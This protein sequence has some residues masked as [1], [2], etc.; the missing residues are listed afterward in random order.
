MRAAS[1]MNPVV[2]G[3]VPLL[4]EKGAAQTWYE[5]DAAWYA[6]RYG[7][8][9]MRK[10]G[11]APL[12]QHYLQ[13][14]RQKG[15]SP[16]SYFDEAWYLRRYAEVEAQVRRGDIASGFAHYCANSTGTYA[17]HWLFDP[18]Y[19]RSHDVELSARSKEGTIFRDDYDH[20]LQVGARMGLAPSVFFDEA[21]YASSLSSEQSTGLRKE[22]GYRHYLRRFPQTLPELRLSSYFEPFAYLRKYPAVAVEIL[23]GR[24]SSALE[25]FLTAPDHEQFRPSALFSERRY[26]ELN[27]DLASYVERDGSNRAA[28]KHFIRF[29][30]A[31]NRKFHDAIDL[32]DYVN[33]NPAVRED[34]ERG[35]APNAYVHFVEIGTRY[36]LVAGNQSQNLEG[37]E[38]ATKRAFRNQAVLNMLALG[39]SAID[40]SYIGEPDVSVIVVLH[41][42]FPLTVSALASLR[43][44]YCGNI[45][46]I[47]VDSGST[48]RTLKI[49]NHV[50]GA[51][52]IRLPGNPG[53]LAG[54][55]RALQQVA[56][57]AV[58]YLNNDIVLA[59]RAVE[60]AIRRLK[61]D[62]NIGAVG[63]MLVRTDGRLQEAGSYILRDGSCRGYLRDASPLSP[64]ANFVRD[65]D[66]C[67]AA[68]LMVR[69]DAVRSM[70]GFDPRYA[71]AYYEDTDLCVRML[72]SG[73]RI[74]YDPSVCVTH[75]EFGSA[76]MPASAIEQMRKNQRVFARAH[77]V[78]LQQ[79][80]TAHMSPVFARQ[81]P[82][83][84]RILVIDDQ[85]PIRTL[86]SG[87]VRTN[88]I[89]VALDEMGFRITFYPMRPCAE[90][91][92]TIRSAL[93]DTVEIMHDR[94]VGGLA[95]FLAER[96]GYYDAIWVCR[97]HNLDQLRAIL[98]ND[99]PAWA[100]KTIVD[101]EAIFAVRTMQA[102]ALAGSRAKTSLAESIRREYRNVAATMKI[103][104][105]NVLDANLLRQNGFPNVK[106]LGHSLS[107]IA[108]A[109]GFAERRNLL[110]VGAIHD[111]NAPNLDALAWFV[112][113]VLDQLI[114]EVPDIRLTVA[115]FI[116]E[117]VDLTRF[118]AHPHIDCIGRVDDLGAIYGSHRIFVAPTRIASG[119]PYKVH[120]AAANRI[121]IVM[122]D[123][124]R[125][126][127]D[128]THGREAL[129][130]ATG[131]AK[132][133]ASLILELYHAPELWKSLADNAASRIAQEQSPDAYRTRLAQIVGLGCNNGH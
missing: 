17:P 63:A 8:R 18:S 16:N 112:D 106:T 90:D 101:A 69:A 126:Q 44:N 58:L 103:V 1:I 84:K 45:Q 87:F 14:G 124:L 30:I 130:A 73:K 19:Y 25:H 41:N 52:I 115:G 110:F 123:L 80:N 100:E 118:R 89:I 50:V 35:L 40:F 31:E 119:M 111:Q 127:V 59:P 114:E 57:P 86:G 3:G 66:Y 15:W 36:G 64:E 6:R 9:S 55:N 117:T 97:L 75:L 102:A 47:L 78:W 26:L 121:P 82:G 43:A 72:R 23:K 109:P 20:F 77:H 49:A 5:F 113:N 128:W 67:S 93:P 10:M 12:L 51:D 132:G 48:D 129:A 133:F 4:L 91:L 22:G 104:A 76:T 125:L 28:Y 7:E 74:V 24:W 61:S 107:P 11:A 62:A 38:R 32:S 33:R 37:I 99:H 68:F 116:G 21:V 39:D 122:T 83:P 2:D 13:T 42:Q 94:G 65:V 70:N 34:I 88:D 79:Q 92:L 54:C 29:G 98:P 95:A 60:N 53:Y 96:D 108:S 105:V 71:P 85:V 56:A 131:D 120:E 27:P 81:R 46:M